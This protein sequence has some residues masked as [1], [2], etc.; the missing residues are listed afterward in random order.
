[1]SAPLFI[2]DEVSA[3][4]FR[5][6]GVRIRTPAEDEL[7]QV[8]GW[9]RSNVSFIMITSHYMAMLNKSERESLLRQ[10]Y[11]PVVEVP[12]MRE[13]VAALD[14]ATQFRGKLGV[15]E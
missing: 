2:G 1:M 15:L 6:A 5:L 8:L 4:G 10:E 7:Q 3:A 11:P 9:A 14:L 12:G 13:Q